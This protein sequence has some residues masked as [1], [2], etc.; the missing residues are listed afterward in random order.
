MGESVLQMRN[1]TKSF[2][3][4]KVLANIDFDL[5][6]GHVHAIVG[7][8]GAGKSTL[9]K[10]LTGIYTKD[11]GE[12]TVAGKGVDFHN[13]SDANAAG[14]R[15]IFQELS[16]IQTLTVVEN[17]FLNHEEKKWGFNDD[18]AMQDH[19]EKLLAKLGIDVPVTEKV[20]NLSVGYCQMIEIAKALSED[21]KVLVMDEP[22][23]SL[24]DMEVTQ[25]FKIVR[26]LKSEGVSIVYISHRMNEIL[27]IADEVTVLRDGKRIITEDAKKLTISGIIN[28]M[29]GDAEK[30]AFEYHEREKYHDQSAMIEI[31]GL[32]VD[33]LVK[34]VSFQVHRGE[35]VGLAGLMGSGRTEILEALFGIRKIQNG[36]VKIQ[37]K[38]VDLKNTKK[39][40]ASGIALV[41]EDRRR[42]G[43]VLS[44]SLK[45]NLLIG[46]FQ[47][48]KTK[49]LIDERKLRKISEESIK[50]L[51]IKAENIETTISSLSGGNQQKVV[52][53]KW[54]K[55]DP[56]LFLLDEPTAGIDIG[57]KGEIIKII[58]NYANQGNSVIVVSSEISELLAMCDRI[59]VLVNGKKSRE[60]TR[61]EMK[62]EE[63]IQHAIQG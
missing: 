54:L 4:N 52:I 14:I 59:I 2:Y 9:M 12:I 41:P 34:D 47:R 62:N 44:H 29:L 48:V 16:V 3:G 20:S 61:S 35:I 28:Y 18:K 37:G 33:N 51:N 40:I 27:T 8:N 21:V 46:L 45:D 22:T 31:E 1:I 25:L 36:T 58:E 5:Q 42:E 11:S 50:Q 23:A 24:S 53:A 56:K 63:I 6:K 26:T 15:M 19:A 43:L 38:S 39:A 7:G 32:C 60:L 10:I 30:N 17:I 55:N 57:A 49:L 13:Y